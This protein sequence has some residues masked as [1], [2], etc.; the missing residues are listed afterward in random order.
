MAESKL[1]W[2]RRRWLELLGVCAATALAGCADT[3]PPVAVTGDAACADAVTVTE[4]AVRIRTG[5][6]PRVEL[7][8]HN[9]GAEPVAYEGRVVFIQGTSLGIDTRTGRDAFS[10]TLAPD[11]R[12]SV[13][14][15]DDARD[16]RNTDAYELFLSVTCARSSVTHD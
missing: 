6:I 5:T 15:T 8:L 16:V 7:G 14:A 1:R 9:T 4:V 3:G 13:V 12:T 11:E 10:G 2:S